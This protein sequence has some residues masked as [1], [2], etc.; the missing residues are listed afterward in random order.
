MLVSVILTVFDAGGDDVVYVQAQI[1]Q[2]VVNRSVNN[3][4]RSLDT[5]ELFRTLWGDC[6]LKGCQSVR[7]LA[8]WRPWRGRLGS[9]LVASSSTGAHSPPYSM[10]R[11]RTLERSLNSLDHTLTGCINFIRGYGPSRER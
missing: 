7:S 8:M 11:T 9:F 1:R 4:G 6:C 10:Q 2:R 5:T 3:R